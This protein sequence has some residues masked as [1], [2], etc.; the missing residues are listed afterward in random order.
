MHRLGPMMAIFEPQRLSV[1]D[2]ENLRPHYAQTLRDWR[3]RF[4]AN[5]DKVAAMFDEDFV[6]AW[7]LY[8]CGSIAAFTEGQLQLFQV[9]FRRPGCRSLPFNRDRMQV[10][11]TTDPPTE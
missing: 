6:R 4:D 10:V 11:A 2:V 1:V 9:L 7:R 5:A 3:Q 8:L